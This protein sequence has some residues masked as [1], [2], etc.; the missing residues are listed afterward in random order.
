MGQRDPTVPGRRAYASAILIVLSVVVGCSVVVLDAH[1]SADIGWP[2]VTPARDYW[3]TAGWRSSAPDD[4]GVDPALPTQIEFQVARGYP[5]VRSVLVIRHG[6]LIHERYWHGLDETSGHDVG[7]VTKTVIGVLIGVALA[8]G[9]LKSTNQ[10]LGELLADELPAGADPSLTRVT[11]KQLLTMTSGL[12]GDDEAFNGDPRLHD[13]MLQSP[14]WVRHILGQPLATEPGEHFAY[15]NASSHLLSVIVAKASHQPTMDYARAH[16]LAPLGIETD[17]A[18][19][20]MITGGVDAAVARACQSA[21]VAWMRDPQ[22]YHYGASTLRL[23]ARDL[24]KLGY[25]YLNGGRWQDLQL[26]SA[27]YVSDATSPAGP[28]PNLFMGFGWHWWVAVENGHRTFSARGEGGQYIYV[29]PVLDLVTVITS[30]AD[31]SGADPKILIA[32]T[33]V[34]AVRR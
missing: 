28:S 32:R 3:P 25:L 33:I 21:K 30:D 8:D 9:V 13:S 23:T 4:Q 2:A 5:Q 11:V 27:D 22:G 34:P 6:R 26:V 12:A 10:T 1:Q 19:E 16:L 7:S 15:S 29:V 31:I 18:L 17:G 14:D 20:P 24:A